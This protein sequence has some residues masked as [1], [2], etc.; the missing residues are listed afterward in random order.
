M[1]L[2]PE[3]SEIESGGGLSGPVN[4]LTEESIDCGCSPQYRLPKL[5]KYATRKIFVIL[6]CL[7]GILQS[8]SQSYFYLV[9]ITLAK[10]FHVDTYFI[11]KLFEGKNVQKNRI[12]LN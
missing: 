2:R 11:G 8:G 3:I 4:S 7:I 12:I 1:T 10:K 6:L 9:S 5:T